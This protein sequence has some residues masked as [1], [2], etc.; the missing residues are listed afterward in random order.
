MIDGQSIKR[1]G[2]TFWPRAMHAACCPKAHL[3]FLGRLLDGDGHAVHTIGL[4]AAH[5]EQAA[6]L[7]DGD[8]IAL[9]VLHTPT[10]V[11]AHDRM[12]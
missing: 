5:A 10:F 1:P 3:H 4:A 11:H 7:G 6:V 12:R 8:G 2:A 9:Y